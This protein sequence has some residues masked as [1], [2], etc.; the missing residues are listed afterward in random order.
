MSYSVANDTLNGLV[1][2]GRLLEEIR[3]SSITIAVDTI[4]VSSDALTVNFKAALSAQE[5]TTL[6]ALVA[7][8][9]GEELEEQNIIEMKPILAEGGKR[10]TDIG[11]R[12]T[13]PA[14]TTYT[15]DYLVV[16]DLQIK[17]GVMY[18]DNQHIH[19][20]VSLEIVD[21]DFL[22]AGEWYPA[23][24]APGVPWS[25][26]LPSG[27]PLH[28]YV[29]TFPVDINGESRFDNDAITTTPLNG[30]TI[31]V[32][33]KSYGASDVNCNVGIVAYT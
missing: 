22:Y 2:S 16:S 29:G 30:L 5:Q 6:D 25:V 7:A 9:T 14:G 11:F 4:S 20:H 15:Y 32:T 21:T 19:D 17:G 1:D 24:Y 8:H 3:E 28:M 10:K 31:R 18:S 33:Y 23:E 27:V 12:F 26:A 13:V